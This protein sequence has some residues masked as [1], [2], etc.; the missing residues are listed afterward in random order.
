MIFDWFQLSFV[1]W[2]LVALLLL[3]FLVQLF[4]YLR[5][6]RGIINHF[7]RNQK[8]KEVSETAQ[9]P[10]TVIICAHDKANSLGQNLPAILKQDY[11]EF[12][13]VVVNDASS[14]ET[15]NV[16]VGLEQTY[17]NLYH[18]FIPSKV[19]SVSAKKM[20]VT[21]G[22]KAAKYDILLFTDADCIPGSNQ[23]ISSMMRHFDATHD[24]VFGYSSFNNITGFLKYLIPYDT[25]F[26]ALQFM[27]FS[28]AGKAYKGFGNNLAYRKDLFF[29]N[30]GFASHLN[31]ESGEDDLFIGEVA[32]KSNTSIDVSP[33][34]KMLVSTE[35]VWNCWKDLKTS[36]ISTSPY[37]KIGTKFRIRTELFS[38]FLFYGLSIALLVV[39][40]IGLNIF[41]IVFAGGLFL[42]RYSLQL[43][44][45]NKSAKCLDESRFYLSLPVFD[46]LLP[47][48]N[49]WF[50]IT[51]L[52]HK[53]N[54]YTW[55]VLH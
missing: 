12:Q 20:A 14:D 48:I 10:V 35:E 3:V 31:L 13:V 40:L 5:Y 42:L 52:F 39:G 32:S 4:F 30:R 18:T 16:L 26:T 36:Q 43:S 50:R 21:I 37:Y 2:I 51:L 22:I 11:P 28:E 53:E 8:E 38:R 9:P 19:Q 33:E 17:K 23:W 49:M 44:V 1:V 46:I 25:L 29:K 45:I 6:F 41:L 7:N 15:E 54:T 34:S 47:L 55:R 24:I 27:G